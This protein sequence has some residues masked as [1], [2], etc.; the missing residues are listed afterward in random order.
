MPGDNLRRPLGSA[1][2]ELCMT[3][4]LAYGTQARAVPGSELVFN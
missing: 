4:V 2:P 3:V 1:I